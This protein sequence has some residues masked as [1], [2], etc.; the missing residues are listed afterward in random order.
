MWE[1]QLIDLEIKWYILNCILG[2]MY[3]GRLGFSELNTNLH[4]F[5]VCPS[6]EIPFVSLKNTKCVLSFFSQ[7]SL[8]KAIPALS[9]ILYIDGLNKKI[10]SSGVAF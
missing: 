1:I 7:M 9:F 3:P 10:L 4:T 8:D 5:E 6:T 2:H